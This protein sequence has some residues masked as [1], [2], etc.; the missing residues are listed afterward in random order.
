MY[1]KKLLLNL[2]EFIKLKIFM[3]VKFMEKK[4]NEITSRVAM[5]RGTVILDENVQSLS[6]GLRFINVRVIVP[7]SGTQDD[8]I[9]Q[10]LLPNRII[11][12]NNSKDF[13]DYASSYDFGIVSLE[14][15]SFIDSESNPKKNVTIKLISKAFIEYELWSKRHGFI[16]ELKDNGKHLYRD[17]VD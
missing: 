17:L 6:D 14:G 12:T 5:A 11:I 16:L 7:K 10:E 8:F 4:L 13:I 3:Q 1:K 2:N 9:I 15:L